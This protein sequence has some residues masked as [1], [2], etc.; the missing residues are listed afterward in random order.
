MAI[1]IKAAIPSNTK[2]GGGTLHYWIVG[3]MSGEDARNALLATAP[4]SYNGA[5]L[6]D[7]NIDCLDWQTHEAQA[8]YKLPSVTPPKEKTGN[9][10]TQFN[11]NSGSV[12][13]T[14]SLE[15]V[16]TYCAPCINS[17]PSTWIYS[18]DGHPPAWTMVAG[19]GGI[20]DGDD[21]TETAPPVVPPLTP[22][23]T[24]TNLGDK[25]FGI[26]VPGGGT[27]PAIAPYTGG[28][29]GLT[30][31]SIEGVDI[32]DGPI[33]FTKRVYLDELT[34][35]QVARLA[36]ASRCCNALPWKFWD[37][38]QVR[39]KGVAG[40]DQG[41]NNVEL[42]LEFVVDKNQTDIFV[43]TIG[44]ITKRAHDYLWVYYKEYEDKVSHVITKKPIYAYVERVYGW[45]D[46]AII[47][48]ILAPIDGVTSPQESES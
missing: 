35:D 47:D 44:P 27:T 11:L 5:P 28:A 37:V 48:E 14:R 15:T 40:G 9:I 6:G 41:R 30:K 46:F 4:T 18:N 32:D 33:T 10:F 36:D 38:G 2:A 17:R 20:V 12:H 22:G 34:D 7:Y 8:I 23:K 39:F 42:S 26:L 19:T 29:I 31:D 24:T 16:D 25:A 21:C 43:G 3:T 45:S 1:T 13:I